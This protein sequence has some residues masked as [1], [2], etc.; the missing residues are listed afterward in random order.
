MFKVW[1][2]SGDL[3]MK[4]SR[5][6]VFGYACGRSKWWHEMVKFVSTSVASLALIAVN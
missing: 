3:P 2:W 1:M 6:N 5:T 4:E